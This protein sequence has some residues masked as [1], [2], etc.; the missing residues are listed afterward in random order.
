M[1]AEGKQEFEQ[2]FQDIRELATRNE[3]AALLLFLQTVFTS[4]TN[5]TLFQQLTGYDVQASALYS[6][7]PP[8]RSQYESYV[9]TSDFKKAIHVGTAAAFEANITPLE[10]ALEE[11]YLTD[12]SDR[13][14]VL[15]NCCEV[16]FYTGQA[17]I[18]FPSINLQDYFR[19]LNWTAADAFRSAERQTWRATPNS[20]ELSGYV[21]Q[22]GNFTDVIL[23]RAGHYA[24]LDETKAA[25]H[26]MVNFI[27][28]KSFADTSS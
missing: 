12:I 23:L 20:T 3:T 26:M 9:Q 27:E 7:K 8:Q 24:A 2:R 4:S 5:P 1:T 15:L 21:F 17:D 14:E 6:T 25:Y 13:L 28:G 22:T 16:L 10:Y 11:D 18:L 19:S